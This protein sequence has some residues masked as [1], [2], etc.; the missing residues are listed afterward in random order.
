M[1]IY[2]NVRTHSFPQT[3]SS[4]IAAHLPRV[5]RASY[6]PPSLPSEELLPP[7]LCVAKKTIPSLPFSTQLASLSF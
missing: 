7:Q 2:P 4:E 1:H 6:T 3:F 5:V